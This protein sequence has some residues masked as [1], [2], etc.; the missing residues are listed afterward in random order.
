M[1]QKVKA[2]KIAEATG[3]QGVCLEAGRQWWSLALAGK[4]N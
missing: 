2:V 4:M 3:Q 1:E